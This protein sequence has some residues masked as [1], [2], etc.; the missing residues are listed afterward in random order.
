MLAYPLAYII[1]PLHSGEEEKH[2]QWGGEGGQVVKFP[3]AIST[4]PPSGWLFHKLRFDN[5]SGPRGR[6]TGCQLRQQ[7]CSHVCLLL[8]QEVTQAARKP[9]L[10]LL[11]QMHVKNRANEWKQWQ[12]WVPGYPLCFHHLNNDVC[13]RYHLLVTQKMPFQRVK[14]EEKRIHFWPSCCRIRKVSKFFWSAFVNHLA[15]LHSR[16]VLF[17]LSVPNTKWNNRFISGN[18]WTVGW[19]PFVDNEFMFYNLVGSQRKSKHGSFI[20][21]QLTAKSTKVVPG[22]RNSSSDVK[23]IKKDGSAELSA[24]ASPEDLVAK[25]R[26]SGSMKVAEA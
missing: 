13:S 20:Y 15:F 11:M 24:N 5:R 12:T 17:C 8:D 19:G 6:L 16:N 14:I 3:L 9:D 23:T 4:L 22:A 25:P 21:I 18:D 1:P 2:Q 10:I 7:P 26:I